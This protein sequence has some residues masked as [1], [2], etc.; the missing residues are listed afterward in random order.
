MGDATGHGVPGAFM[1]ILGLE[2]IHKIVKDKGVYLPDM[3]L[4]EMDNDIR[5]KLHQ[6]SKEEQTVEDTLEGTA[7]MIEGSKMWVSSA[8]RPFVVVKNDGILE[9]HN[10]TKKTIGGTTYSHVSGFDITNLNL[11]SGDTLYLFSDGKLRRVPR[12]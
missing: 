12:P 8:M 4:G 2:S 9:E 1:S 11:I 7:L 3:I 10:P 6:N 5:N